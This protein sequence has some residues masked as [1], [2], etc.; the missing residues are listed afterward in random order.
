M[1]ENEKQLENTVRKLALLEE[2]IASSMREPQTP[3]RDVSVRSLES[4]VRQM[5][6]EIVRY[7]SKVKLR[8]AG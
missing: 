4:L 6:E 2:Q 7:R 8:D 1:I 5:K 3:E